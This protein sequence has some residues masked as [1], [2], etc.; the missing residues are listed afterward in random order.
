MILVKPKYRLDY[1]IQPKAPIEEGVDC[2]RYKYL[3]YLW[4]HVPGVQRVTSLDMSKGLGGWRGR[5][6]PLEDADEL[7]MVWWSWKDKP[8]HPRGHLGTFLIGKSGLLEVTHASTSR[9][10][11]VHEELKGKLM[12]DIAVIRRITIGDK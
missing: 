3:V 6:I 4:A 5:D 1:R 11:I 7:D 8:H 12:D 10:H 2:S 9:G